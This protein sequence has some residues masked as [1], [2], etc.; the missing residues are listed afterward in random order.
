MRVRWG[1]ACGVE[2]GE[3]VQLQPYTLGLQLSRIP[4]RLINRVIRVRGVRGVVPNRS[5]HLKTCLGIWKRW[6]VKISESETRL[7][8][9]LHS[10]EEKGKKNAD[11]EK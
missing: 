11:V 6:I 9:G 3:S 10:E 1:F 2:W 8:I 4:T 5:G 7:G